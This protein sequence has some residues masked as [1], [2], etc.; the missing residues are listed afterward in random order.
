[1]VLGQTGVAAMFN[2]SNQRRLL[3]GN[4]MGVFVFW[5]LGESFVLFCSQCLSAK[6]VLAVERGS[7]SSA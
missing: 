7:V 5:L 6:A 3:E 1:M 2:S 4:N